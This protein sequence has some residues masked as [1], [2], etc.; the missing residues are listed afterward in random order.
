MPPLN[1]NFLEKAKRRLETA[2][3]ALNKGYVCSS[4]SNC[5][6]A[7]FNLMQSVVGEPPGGKWSHGGLP[8]N[9]TKVVYKN[10]ILS[11]DEIKG[12]VK[13]CE[14]LYALRKL[15]DYYDTILESSEEERGKVESYM[16]KVERLLNLIEEAY[17]EQEA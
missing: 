11:K 17:N 15:A 10:R 9:F 3:L 7:L 16:L 5:Y 4:C 6:Y 14:N 1:R 12:I 13:T 8:K 2:K